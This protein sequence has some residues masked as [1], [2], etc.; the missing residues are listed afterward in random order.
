MKGE[1]KR[2]FKEPNFLC[3]LFAQFSKLN[4]ISKEEEFV[5]LCTLVLRT[6][7]ITLQVLEKHYWVN[8]CP[9]LLSKFILSLIQKIWKDFFSPKFSWSLLPFC[10]CLVYSFGGLDIAILI[11]FAFHWLLLD[12]NLKF[13]ARCSF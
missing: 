8:E 11:Y 13:G 4:I 5:L 6:M 7:L 1:Q 10:L 3:V 12:Y 9:Y 2:K